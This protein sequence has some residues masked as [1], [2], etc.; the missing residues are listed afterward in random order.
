MYKYKICL[1]KRKIYKLLRR[2]SYM[3][4]KLNPN[5][6]RPE[7][8]KRIYDLRTQKEP[9]R[10]ISA[11]IL[12]EFDLK[13]TEPTIKNIYNR[14]VAKNLLVQNS[15]DEKTAKE[16]VP[17]YQAKMEARFDRIV[18]VTDDLMDT[19]ES[20]KKNMPPALY[21][22]FVPTI[23]M[24]CR[25]ILNQLTYIKKE[26]TQVLIN[27]KNMIYSPLQIMNVINKEFEEKKIIVVGVA[28]KNGRVLTTE[29]KT[30]GIIK[31]EEE[32]EL[33]RKFEEEKE[34]EN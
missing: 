5:Y 1:D 24:V 4:F 33:D 15:K 32:L 22:K 25:E 34:I 26:Q 13:I 14:F 2:K 16:V 17:D 6:S 31:T 30:S 9:W 8:V 11:I 10:N 29:E 3:V 18:K 19:L 20:L 23:L 27:Q 7:I 21:I 28:P 12:Q